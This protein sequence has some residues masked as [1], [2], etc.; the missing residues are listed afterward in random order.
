MGRLVL[1]PPVLSV[2]SD[3]LRLDERLERFEERLRLL[4]RL[5]DRDEGMSYI[6][7][8]EKNQHRQ[9]NVNIL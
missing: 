2:A 7:D 9:P 4:E 5:D 6:Y 3:R 1:L 8:A